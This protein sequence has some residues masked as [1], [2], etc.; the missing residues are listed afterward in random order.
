MKDLKLICQFISAFPVRERRSLYILVIFLVAVGVLELITV[1]ALYPAV[2]SIIEPNSI[3]EIFKGNAFF[4]KSNNLLVDQ[5]GLLLLFCILLVVTNLSRLLMFK[6]SVA[7]SF[8]VAATINAR[9][10]DKKIKSSYQTWKNEARSDFVSITTIKSGI[11]VYNIVSPLVVLGSTIIILFLYSCSAF[12]FVKLEYVFILVIAVFFYLAINH[13]AKR[14][15][16]NLSIDIDGSVDAVSKVASQAYS[17]KQDIILD[18]SYEWYASK[19]SSNENKLRESQAAASFISAMPRYLVET[20]IMAFLI[21]SVYFS[22]EV[23]PKLVSEIAVIGFA[24]LRLAPILQQAYSSLASIQGYRETIIEFSEVLNQKDFQ[25]KNATKKTKIQSISLRDVFYRHPNSNKYTLKGINFEFQKGFVYGISGPSGVGKST[26]LEIV[27]GLLEPT[28]GKVI[29]MDDEQRIVGK[30][31]ARGKIG[32]LS[33]TPYIVEGNARENVNIY[34]KNFDQDLFEQCLISS[35]LGYWISREEV[36]RVF[37]SD[38]NNLSGGQR[39]RL[40]LARLLYKKKDLIVLDEFTNGVDANTEARILRSIKEMKKDKI[41]ILVSH[42][43][44]AMSVCD[45]V[46]ELKQADLN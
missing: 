20:L 7:R 21:L 23:G 45:E 5:R 2:M 31:D 14:K 11:L 35:G 1:G 38:G 37:T 6:V 16:Y 43:A 4:D 25:F 13:I 12:F 27:S 29:Y 26:L 32:Y 41:I 3:N 15:L 30:Q 8:L 34:S 22:K 39:Q 9:I 46:F 19:F 10:F 44:S 24:S 42:R 28:T 40:S 36:D 18:N 33:Q 17:A